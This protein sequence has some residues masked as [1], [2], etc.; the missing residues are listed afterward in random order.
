M[1]GAKE[2]I[3]NGAQVKV[4]MNDGKVHLATLSEVEENLQ[5][6]YS[7]PLPGATM[8]A[9]H[10]LEELPGEG[11]TRVTHKFGYIGLLSGFYH[12]LTRSYVKNGLEGNTLGLKNILEAPEADF[13]LIPK[14]E[15]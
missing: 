13:V 14:S 5:F 1:T 2:G 11:G 7:A 6:S 15:E 3:K 8:V 4:V 9:G 12:L 10:F